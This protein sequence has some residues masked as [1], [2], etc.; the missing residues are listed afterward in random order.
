[1]GTRSAI[2]L[3]LTTIGVIWIEGEEDAAFK[4]AQ[5]PHYHARDVAWL[6]AQ[7]EQAVLVLSSSHPCLETKATVEQHGIVIRKLIPPDLRPSVQI[8]DL[9]DH[10]YGT[11][12]SQPLVRAITQTIGRKAGVLLFSTGRAMPAPSSV[13]TAAR[14]LAVL[15]AVWR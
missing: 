13:V 1:M 10:G 3:P 2:F 14:F 9:R 5:E 11:V 8:V 4:E 7:T 6:R 12:L 15:P